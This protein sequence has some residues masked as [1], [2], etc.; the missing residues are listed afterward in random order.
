[1]FTKKNVCVLDVEG[2]SG[3]R[4]YNVGYIIGDLH[5]NVIVR[6][7]FGLMPFIMENLSTAIKSAQETPRKMTHKNIKGILEN[8]VKYHWDMPQTFFDR[9][10]Q[11]LVEN[12]VKEIWAYNCNFDSSAISKVMEYLNKEDTLN[13][14]GI[15]WLDIWSAIVMTK[16]CCK[17]YVKFCRKN[18]FITEKGNCKT[19]AEVVWGYLTNNSNFEEEHTGLADC[20][21]EYQILLAAKSTKKKIDGTIGNPWKLV[22]NFCEQNNL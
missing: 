12:D 16:C 6:R 3:K 18:G 15:S 8:P 13:K 22:K 11:D 19:S 14:M 1:M 5:G 20:E 4:P 10:I 9:F 7:S 21:I 2:M 17:K